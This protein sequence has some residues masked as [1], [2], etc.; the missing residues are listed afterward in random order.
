MTIEK[1][2]L[3][4]G[5]LLGEQRTLELFDMEKVDSDCHTRCTTS[6]TD[7]RNLQQRYSVPKSYLTL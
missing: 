3:D 4:S 5:I 7:L 2:F 6:I 1:S